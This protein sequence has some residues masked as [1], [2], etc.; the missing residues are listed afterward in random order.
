M[1]TAVSNGVGRL[2][3]LDA[4]TGEWRYLADTDKLC[5]IIG[6]V[7]ARLSDTSALVIGSGT[8][9]PNT[10]Y[11]IDVS[12]EG[13]LEA[14]R[15]ANDDQLPANLISAPEPLHIRSKASPS[16]DIHG[17]LWMPKNPKFTGPNEVLPPLILVVHGGPTGNAG[18]GLSLRTQYFTSR[19]YALLQLNYTGST[20]YGREYRESLFGNW[21][22]VD[23]D[24]AAE[25]ADYLIQT[26]RVRAES[27]GI[28]GGSA[29]GYNTLQVLSMHP[30]KFTAGVCI[31]GISDLE[32]FDNGTHKLESDYAD[33]LVI[34]K[35][36]KPEDRLKI[37]HQ[38][39]AMYHTD[40]MKS[41]L[42]LIHGVKDT[43][44]PVQQARVIAEA[45][46]KMKR[47]VAIMELEEEGHMMGEPSSVRLWLEE[48]ERWWQKTLIKR[49]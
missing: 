1:A 25:A 47:D 8:A 13:G 24:D 33:A 23:S 44:V 28:T 41:P 5:S 43:V 9:T 16:R 3:V 12:V 48:E 39:S 34:A 21:G 49:S 19:G 26:G 20:G 15:A 29:G 30:D 22:V 32:T 2:V 10:L 7:V 6:D 37:Y 35:G 11:R 38:R 46:K 17:F 31:S 14:L 18:Q 40:K 27:I 36:T 4:K 45:L 42:L